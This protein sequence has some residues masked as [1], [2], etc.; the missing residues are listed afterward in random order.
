M[1][2]SMLVKEPFLKLIGESKPVFVNV[3]ASKQKT[4]ESS[5]PERNVTSFERLTLRRLM[6]NIFVLLRKLFSTL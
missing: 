2:L 6:P 4:T 1:L 5:E 3:R